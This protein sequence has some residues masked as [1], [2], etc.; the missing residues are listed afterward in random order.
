MTTQLK[1]ATSTSTRTFEAIQKTLASH[2]ARQIVFDYGDDGRITAI[3]FSIEINSN[4][5]PFRLPARIENVERILYPGRRSLSVAQKDQAYR[6]A[7]ANIRDWIAAQMAMVDTG[8]VR[9]EEVLLPYL[10]NSEG[11]TFFE[12]MQERHFLLTSGER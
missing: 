8:M 4:L 12:A 5:C 6:T 3:A 11:Q 1:N 9:P 2:K 10:I 7:W